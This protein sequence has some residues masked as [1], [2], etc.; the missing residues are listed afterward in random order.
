MSDPVLYDAN[1]KP[2]VKPRPVVRIYGK[3][4]DCRYV[5]AERS[6]LIKLEDAKTHKVSKPI[7]VSATAFPFGHSDDAMVEFAKQLCQRKEPLLLEF[8]P[9]DTTGEVSGYIAP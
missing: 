4:L 8:N 1:G 6:L 5:A 9:N 2:I 3:V 7:Q